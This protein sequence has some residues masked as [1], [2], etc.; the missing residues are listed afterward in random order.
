MKTYDTSTSFCIRAL[1]DRTCKR[2]PQ[3]GSQDPSPYSRHGAVASELRQSEWRSRRSDH[4]ER[5]RLFPVRRLVARYQR[6]ELTKSPALRG[7]N[8]LRPRGK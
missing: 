5:H 8:C 6:Q 1:H 4:V 3:A 2:S 7:A